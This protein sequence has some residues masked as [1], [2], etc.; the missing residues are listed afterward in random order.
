MLPPPIKKEAIY[1]EKFKNYINNYSSNNRN[2]SL[3]P[4]YCFCGYYGNINQIQFFMENCYMHLF[5]DRLDKW[6]AK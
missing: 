4:C 2:N 3:Y 5:C 6:L 1:D